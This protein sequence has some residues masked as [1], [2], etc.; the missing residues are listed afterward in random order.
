[1]S[2]ISDL[3]LQVV[4]VDPTARVAKNSSNIYMNL[5]AHISFQCIPNISS[6]IYYIL[7][8]RSFHQKMWNSGVSKVRN[9]RPVP[10]PEPVIRFSLNLLGRMQ[11]LVM[12]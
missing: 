9:S 8:L 4:E 11:K 12:E 7:K 6:R 10:V 2:I 3:H 1:M 5:V